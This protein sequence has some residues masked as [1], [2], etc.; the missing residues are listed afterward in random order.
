LTLEGHH[1]TGF[2]DGSQNA[3]NAEPL[4]VLAGAELFPAAG[5]VVVTGESAGSAP[6][7]LYAGLLADELPDGRITVIAD[8]SGAYPDVPGINALIGSLWNKLVSVPDWPEYADIT[9]ETQSLLGLFIRVGAHAPDIT[10]ARHDYAFD[11][12]QAFFGNLGGFEADDLVT[13]IDLNETQIEASGVTLYSFISPG[14]SHTVFSKTALYTETL[15]GTSLRDWVAALVARHA[16]RGRALHR[17]HLT[18]N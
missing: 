16:G 2:G 8:G 6:T 15:N 11:E 17:M 14:G 4:S 3:T 1:L 9:A 10:F 13:L 7:P 18:L 5:E 12:T